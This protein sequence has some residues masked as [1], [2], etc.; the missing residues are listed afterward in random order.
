M[1]RRQFIE[2]FGAAVTCVLL[3]KLPVD[4][5]IRGWGERPYLR[6]EIL[7]NINARNTLAWIR[8]Q[9]IDKVLAIPPDHFTWIKARDIVR[10]V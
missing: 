5:A 6:G 10:E 1:D 9:I 7:Q 8:E 2:A 4:G 3:G